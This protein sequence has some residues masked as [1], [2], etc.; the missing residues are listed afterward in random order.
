MRLVLHIG[1]EKTATTTLQHFLY[2]NRAALAARGVD[3]SDACGSPNNR[4]LAAYC[5]PK[6][7]FDN[8]FQTRGIRTIAEKE[9]F[10]AAFE[11][12]FKAEVA[13]LQGD[14]LILTSEHLHSRLVDRASVEKLHDLLA[15][16]FSEIRVIC[17]FR[18][19][20]A[21]AK[22][23]YST[24][25]KG[26][27]SEDFAGFLE[28]C[29][30][31][32]HRYNY[33]SSF[34]LWA[35]LFG[36]EALVARLFDKTAFKGGDICADFL[37]QACGFEMDGFEPVG[38]N[39]NESLGAHGLM[40]GRI[41]NRT[42]PRYLPDGSV[43]PLRKALAQTLEATDLAGQGVLGFEAAEEVHAR[44]DE[45]NR[46]FARAFLGREDNPFAAPRARAGGDLS[47]APQDLERFWQQMM[48]GLCDLPLVASSHAGPLRAL[49]RRIE[50]GETLGPK[51]A[52]MLK[53]LARAIRGKPDK[54]SGTEPD[55]GSGSG[56][57]S[58]PE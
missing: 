10:F 31:E 24:A 27:K 17:Y 37:D 55:S 33:H 42:H 25:I 54:P 14:T 11:T 53:S 6:A 49:A 19:Q 44:F 8:F 7:R 15:P 57:N 51:E 39:Q 20:A 9:A 5:Q 18:E 43:N 34:S 56:S 22:S 58:A 16:L 21:V 45:S 28:G 50:A 40:L 1:T 32:N 26:G 13:G 29:I 35:D 4:R 3:L 47:I 48:E 36:K 23:L 2:H 52:R 30:P 12:D 46:A 41:T 38:A